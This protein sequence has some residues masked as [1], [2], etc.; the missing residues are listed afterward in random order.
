[1]FPILHHHLNQMLLGRTP[2]NL[3]ILGSLWPD[4]AVFSGCSRDEAHKCGR[5]VYA[6]AAE[7]YKAGLPF[8]GGIISHAVADY[9]G[10]E[11]WGSP[12]NGYCFQA[13]LPYLAQ[14]A[15][16]T[17]LPARYIPWKGHNFV[18]MAFELITAENHPEYGPAILAALAD[19]NTL[20]TACELMQLYNGMPPGFCQTALLQGREIF[21]LEGCDAVCLAETQHLSYI[22]LFS[23]DSADQEAMISLLRQMA[24]ELQVSYDSFIPQLLDLMRQSVP[25]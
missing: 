11:K 24:K 21:A 8:A 25:L 22:R 23:H 4:L 14:V 12:S 13:A 6:L 18:E 17:K 7:Q 20:A 16:A 10:D 5:A 3:T 9:Y 19:E 1:M 2:A 15:A